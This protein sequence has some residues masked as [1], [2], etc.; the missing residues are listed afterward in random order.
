M[1]RA[2]FLAPW[3]RDRQSGRP[4]V[5]HVVSRVVDRRY[6]LGAEE[7]EVFRRMMRMYEGFSGVRVQTYC[8]MSNH[9]HLLLEVP[10]RP[11]EGLDDGE[12]LRRL[13][14]L[15][16]PERVADVGRLLAGRRA[17]GADE[18]AEGIKESYL[19][20]MWD[21][22]QFMKGLKQRF[23][24]WFNRRHERKGTLWEDRFKSVV[25]EDGWTGKVV[26]A[27]IDLN[28]VRGGIVT[29]P[30]E[31]RWSGYGEAVGG[32]GAAGDAARAGLCRLWGEADP[33]AW[34]RSGVAGA[35]RVFL[36]ER[37]KE[38]RG[39]GEGRGGAGAARRGVAR[40]A[41]VR[42]RRRGGRLELPE[43][44]R[45]RVRY[46]SDGLVIGG[47]AFVDEVFNA[48]RDHFGARRRSGARPL[49][50]CAEPLYA[51]RALANG[52]G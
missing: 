14:F 7:R 20:R 49:R 42:E 13:G 12:F 21:L 44:L 1:R 41:V 25:V 15:Y 39:E 40:E 24:Q 34:T 45:R 11:G 37:G 47:R 23:T 10:Q 51:M 5:Y 2:R 3:A 26:A 18:A 46:F 43:L 48:R 9:F 6:V 4:A 33:G 36:F 27:Y 30:A 8:V 52:Y 35:Y 32:L 38:R 50:G 28:P 22:S 17:A 31:Y 29:E 16:S 19:Y